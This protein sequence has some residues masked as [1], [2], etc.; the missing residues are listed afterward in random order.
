MLLNRQI[1]REYDI[2]GKVGTDLTP[3]TV[4][5]VA[6]AYSTYLRDRGTTQAIVGR[7]NRLS[8]GSFR[9]AV[10]SGLT[11]SGIDVTDIGLVVT[12]L[13]YF[14]RVL[15]G[16]D[17]GVMVT[18]SHNPPEDNGFKLAKDF[19]TLYGPQIQEIRQIAEQA[20][21][22][23]GR[24]GVSRADPREE[25]F[26]AIL[27]RVSLGPRRI[28]VALDCG[29][30]IASLF[31]PDLL[32]RLGCDIVPI[33]CE[34]NGTF[35]HHFPDPVKKENLTDLTALVLESGADVG[36]SYDGD[37]DRIGV[38]DDKGNILWGDVL[39]AIYWREVLASHPGAQAIIEVKCSQALVDEV[40][41]L[42]GRPFFYKTGHS[43]IKAKMKE[44][45]AVFCGEMSGH[46]FFADEYFGFD[47]A[48]YPSCRLLRNLSNTQAPLSEMA[49]DIPQYVSTPEIRVGC[50][51]ESKFDV[52]DGI[53]RRLKAEYEVIDIDGA[54]VQVFGGW[55]LVRASNTQPALVLR[56]E[57]R[58]SASV[59]KI[60]ALLEAELSRYPEVEK[61]R[62]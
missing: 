11:G 56:C 29:N 57:A 38:V 45:G 49:A 25:Y 47:D 10:V 60:K 28:K 19:A 48:Q 59:D 53:T 1:F 12:P 33:Y 43:L 7:D 51:D 16:I 24:G 42:G 26:K 54:R 27:E 9:D 6:R 58:D 23:S 32:R 22:Y 37:A 13:F 39:M 35:P 61:I 31:A 4:T 20:R 21:F 17:G 52:V 14:A 55:G 3:E 36:I 62:W 34:S 41:R 46:M 30:G 44:I 18:G 5:T 15:Y 40:E 50:P 8:S 2:R